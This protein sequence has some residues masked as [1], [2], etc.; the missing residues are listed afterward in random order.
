MYLTEKSLLFI[1]KEFQTRYKPYRY[2]GPKQF[3]NY[4]AGLNEH[5]NRNCGFL[6]YSIVLVGDKHKANRM[7]S[8]KENSKQLA[9]L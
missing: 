6:S 2:Q 8:N 4:L 9:Q 3:P 7:I 1:A 5:Q